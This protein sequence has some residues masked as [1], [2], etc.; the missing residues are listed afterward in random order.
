MSEKANLYAQ[1]QEAAADC[2][3]PETMAALQKTILLPVIEEEKAAFVRAEYGRLQHI[4]GAAY[5]EGGELHF[6]HPLP[7]QEKR[8]DVTVY[9]RPEEMLRIESGERNVAA[10]EARLQ[11]YRV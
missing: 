5:N 1:Y 10:A 3:T 8:D 9:G 6:F 11:R 2:G 7:E 4:M